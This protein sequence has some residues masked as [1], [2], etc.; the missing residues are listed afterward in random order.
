MEKYIVF[1][2]FDGTITQQDVIMSIMEHF[3]PPIWKEI[4][5]KIFSKEITI[6][7]GVAK[8]FSLI[9]SS[10]KDEIVKWCLENI[11]IRDGFKD[12]LKY[13]KEK[14]VPFIVLSGGLDFYI[15][16]I[17][18]PYKNLITEIYCNEADF[19]KKFIKV[20]FKYSCDPLCNED[21]GMCKT[22]V[23]RKYKKKYKE[24]IYIGDSITDI[25][26]SKIADVVF[27]QGYLA[28]ILDKIG[29]K[30]FKYETFYDIKN[31][32]KIIL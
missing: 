8:L 30:Y 26:S 1:S 14:N 29:I 9:P 19:S 16:P 4:K 10:K 17:L 22:S 5:D 3:A 24:V 11:K 12:F 28:K 15:Y 31:K 20:K 23:I 25:E 13:L 2:D 27:A 32:L 18:E 6:S 7:E 21:C